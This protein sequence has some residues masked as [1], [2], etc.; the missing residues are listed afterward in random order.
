MPLNVR[1]VLL[2]FLNPAVHFEDMNTMRELKEEDEVRFVDLD[3]PSACWFLKHK[4]FVGIVAWY[5]HISGQF[6]TTKPPR[7][8]QMVV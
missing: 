4:H 7:S 1:K 6:L 3:K 8:P 2:R 5:H